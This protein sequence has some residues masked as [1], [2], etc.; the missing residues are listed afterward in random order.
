MKHGLVVI[1]VVVLVAA[2]GVAVYNV[3]KSRQKD[4]QTV[5]ASPSPAT[6]PASTAS[7][8]ATPTPTPT[9][10]PTDQ[11]LIVAALKSYYSSNGRTPNAGSRFTLCKLQGDYA[12]AG[13]FVGSGA[14]GGEAWLKK[15][16]GA[17]SVVWEGQNYDPATQ[18]SKLGFPQ[19]FGNSCSSNSPVIYTY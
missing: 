16:Q 13:Y 10:A 6:S 7:P 15:S 18:A 9:P 5:K 11:Q 1:L 17:W 8:V 12:I 2:A 19:G 4:A 14:G 3:Q